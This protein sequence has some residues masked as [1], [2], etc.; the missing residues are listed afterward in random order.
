[1]SSDTATAVVVDPQPAD[2]PTDA[3]AVPGDA[4]LAVP[5]ARPLP[6]VAIAREDFAPAQARMVALA[7]SRIAEWTAQRDELVANVEVARRNKWRHEPMKRAARM[8]ERMVTYYTAIREA[9]VNGYMIMPDLQCDVYAVRVRENGASLPA[10][11]MGN[12]QWL[13]HD[14][15]QGP[16]S[17][18]PVGE[19]EYVSDTTVAHRHHE[20]WKDAQ[21]REQTTYFSTALDN[22]PPEAPV[23]L[24]RPVLLEAAERAMALRVFDEIGIVG[25]NRRSRTADPMLVGRINDPRPTRRGQAFL[26]AW[27]F[28]P[29]SL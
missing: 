19:G 24:A 17:S 12:S 10:R 28:A 23:I 1:M 16:S 20:K 26:I 14:P 27:W 7:E 22:L 4:I 2:Q 15:R 13:T 8:A 3:L 9:L 21:D 29:A 11:Q 6:I 5:G 18:L 25:A